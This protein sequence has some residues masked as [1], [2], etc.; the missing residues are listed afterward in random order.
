MRFTHLILVLLIGL[1]TSCGTR[2]RM[3]YFQGDESELAGQANYTP[4]FKTDDFLSIVVTAEDPESAIPFNFPTV[5]IREPINFS[6]TSG[7]PSKTGYLIDAEGFVDLP[8]LGKI[9]VAGLNR[10]ELTK[11][12]Q[13]KYTEYLKHPVVNIQIQNFKVTVLGDV[14][15]PGTFLIPNER[16]TLFEAIGLAGDLNMTGKRNNILIIR[17]RNGE[18][19]QY[20]INLTTKEALTSPVYYLEQNDMVYVEPNAAARSQGTFWRTS[21]TIFISITSLIVTSIALIIR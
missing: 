9:H 15:R 16:I 3:V 8:V 6:Y 5:G 12:L 11:I 2:Q 21:G 4:V 19:I 20:R 13:D 1:I 18:K 10:M 7:T 17:D 14:S